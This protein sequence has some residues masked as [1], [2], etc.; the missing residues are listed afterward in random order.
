MKKTIALHPLLFAAYPVLLLYGSN[1]TLISF[2]ELGRPLGIVLG[3]SGLAWLGGTVALRDQ[4]K[5]AFVA[6]ALVG[7]L[8][9]HAAA[10]KAL[11]FS[12]FVNSWGAFLVVWLGLW[13]GIAA[14]L[15][16]NKV[17]PTIFNLFSGLMVIQAIAVIGMGWMRAARAVHPVTGPITGNQKSATRPPDIFYVI[18][19]GYGRSDQ[20]KRVMSYDNDPFVTA[21]EAR[22]FYV[23]KDSH[24]NYC[25]TELSVSSSL[26]YDTI[27]NLF[28]SVPK[29]ESDRTLFQLAIS[30]NR[31]VKELRAKG[32]AFISVTTGF[33]S[34]HFKNAD[35]NFEKG[36]S[37]SL[38]E[39][40]LLDQYTL[41][42]GP[43]MS[44]S[45]RAA[46][47]E[48]LADA[49]ENMRVLAKPTA[50]PRFVFV[51]IL[52]PHPSFVYNSDGS[53]AK[54][55]GAVPGLVDGSDYMLNGGTPEGYRRGYTGQVQW[56]NRQ[57]INWVDYMLAEP[58]AKPIV[59]IQG[60]HG[61]K[62]GLDQNEISKTDL[63]ECFSNLSAFYVSSKIKQKLYPSIT[64]VNSFRIIL[65][66]LFDLELPL[67]P[68][69]SYYS[70][71]SHPMRLTDVTDRL[72]A[73]AGGR[74]LNG[75]EG[76]RGNP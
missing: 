27:P 70:P 73:G 23:A 10:W 45:I 66:S 7:A 53:S 51:H 16:L 47:R 62:L 22:G 41:S 54:A 35:Q 58:G 76:T 49:F 42:E 31:L 19:D 20:L 48:Q 38:L 61:S 39:E 36:V 68:D 57:L 12:I 1:L 2:L 21:L 34:I 28:P 55:D 3:V 69:R 15:I 14:V 37:V 65:Q 8:Y 26:N 50:V 75:G 33:P 17:S 43:N 64:P 56:L 13:G 25:Q 74:Q 40:T 63:R 9:L 11:G 30:E 32:Y 46:K 59:L 24:S 29:E 18:V 71:Y 4:A 60:D 52:A 44:H 72:Q 6:S 67:L 5:G